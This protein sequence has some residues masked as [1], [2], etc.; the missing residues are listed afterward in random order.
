[1]A[2]D[3][4]KNSDKQGNKQGLD[5]KGAQPGYGGRPGAQ[6]GAAQK[7]QG[8]KKPEQQQRRGQNEEE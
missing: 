6:K 8:V 1:M 3:N 2:Q 5:Q 4:K 7:P